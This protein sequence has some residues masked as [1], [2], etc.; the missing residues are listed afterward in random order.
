MTST[1]TMDADVPVFLCEAIDQGRVWRFWCPPCRGFHHHGAG[2][3]HRAAHC[4][5]AAGKAAAPHGYVIRIDP[6]H[7]A[8]Q[9]AP[10]SR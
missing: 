9:P 2:A 8:R 4:H 5:S 1:T 10:G 7:R 6:S 3:G